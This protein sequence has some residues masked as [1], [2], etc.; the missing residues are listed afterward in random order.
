MSAPTMTAPIPG[1]WFDGQSSKARPVLVS[2]RAS[3][4]GPSLVLHPLTQPGAE[5]RVFEYAD[6]VWPEAWNE[7]KP[8]P[9]VVVDLQDH[10]SVEIDAVADWRAALAAAGAR[11]GIAQ[12]MQT[13]WPVLLG[14]TA[15][16]VIGLTL[17]YRYGTPWA[18]TQL[19]RFVRLGWETS[20]AEN[21]LR[22][23]DD[24]TL[25]PS[26]LPKERQDQL[27]ARFDTLV[28]QTPHTLH[29]Y[30]DYRPPL[31]LEFR[32]GMGANAFALPGGKIVM[33]DGIVKA[34][35]EKG[36]PD[37]ALVGVLAHEI[38]H[39]VYRHGTRMVVEQGVLNMGL[40]LALGDVSV[41]VSTG[42]SVLTG[43]AYS[44]SHER[45]ADCYAIALMR[46]AA[47]PTAPMG[48]LLLAIA[49]DEEQEE[50]SRKQKENEKDGKVAG[51]KGS[52]APAASAS[53]ATSTP[54]PPAKGRARAELEAH[55][56]WSLLSSHPDTVRRATELEQGHAPHCGKG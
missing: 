55:P 40:G 33:T 12:R 42:A 17:F 29:R 1:R 35:A 49:H 25:K 8:P 48:K 39:V 27:K 52:D 50:K 7:R 31:S 45:E 54:A 24:G 38:G 6:V 11:P 34:A 26:K 30:P 28:Q 21:V 23:M 10:G 20:V 4:Q 19:T 37:D 51:Q 2:L 46:H 43:L 32:A 13:R 18:A 16:A 44:R 36:L 56:V 22:Q 14:V 9:R 53:A 5:P 41:V 3:P 47:L 15:A